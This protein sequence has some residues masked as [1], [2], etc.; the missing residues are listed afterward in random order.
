MIL[1]SADRN[2]TYRDILPHEAIFRSPSNSRTMVVVVTETEL[3]RYGVLDGI[4]AIPVHT[5]LRIWMVGETLE[6]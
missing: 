3:G 6:T 2:P 1:S 4:Y 5:R